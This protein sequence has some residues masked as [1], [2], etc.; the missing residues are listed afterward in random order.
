MNGKRVRWSAI[1]VV[2][3]TWL[4][5]PGAGAAGA[6]PAPSRVAVLVGANLPAPGRAPLLFGHDD[7]SKMAS[8][9]T[10]VAGFHPRDVFVLKDPSAADLLR[11]LRTAAERLA[12]RP[13]SLLYFYYSGHADDRALY[14]AGQPVA[15]S[16]L[17]AVID[18]A[19]VSVRIGMVD[20]CQG[21]AWTRAKGLRPDEPFPVRWPLSLDTEG[22]VLIASSSGLES[23][24]ESDQLRGSFFTHHFA[25]GLSGAADRNGNGEVTITE[26][27]EYAKERTI[28]DTLKVAREAQH[29]SFAVNLRGRRDLVL[30]QIAQARSTLQLS[31]QHGPL[32]LVHIESGV[33]LL[34]L[35]AGPRTVKL[36]VPAG[37]YL[38]RK[39]YPGSIVSKEVAVRNGA[40]TSIDEDQL[41]LVGSLQLA[42]K[43]ALPSAPAL[44]ATLPPPDPTPLWVKAGAWSGAV[45]AAAGIGLNFMFALDIRSVNQ[46]LDA[47][48][49]YPCIGTNNHNCARDGRTPRAEL[50]PDELRF[51]AELQGEGKRFESYQYMAMTAGLI[52][53]AVTVPLVIKWVRSASQAEEADDGKGGHALRIAPSL[54]PGG[55]GLVLDARF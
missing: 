14:P 9:L 42:V 33:T 21:G 49:Q 54:R 32:E 55:A 44:Q 16:E 30:A 43:S 8:V 37:I 7:A 50:K 6:Q 19:R 52:G 3:A 1:L 35:P 41:T 17:R 45:L 25:T 4:A 40:S 28:R 47:F 38:I 5:G 11:A 22:S 53:L 12:D 13:E 2:V 24:H 10:R 51:V 15:L 27:F 29:P 18:Q 39:K 26:A 46:E 23:A 48:R 36:A 34:E 20:A 31:Q